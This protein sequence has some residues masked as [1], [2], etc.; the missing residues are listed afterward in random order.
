MFYY[1]EGYN[2]HLYAVMA[3]DEA[4]GRTFVWTDKE[5]PFVRRA[6][7]E[8]KAYLWTQFGIKLRIVQSDNESVL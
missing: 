5:K 7:M 4:T 1:D 3:I 8:L 2:G 6:V